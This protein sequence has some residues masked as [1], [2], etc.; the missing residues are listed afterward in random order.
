MGCFLELGLLFSDV[1]CT[2]CVCH[3]CHWAVVGNTISFGVGYTVSLLGWETL[4]LFWMGNTVSPLGHF[5][6]LVLEFEGYQI[7]G[8]PVSLIPELFPDPIFSSCPSET[9][10]KYQIVYYASIFS[11]GFLFSLQLVYLFHFHSEVLT[12]HLHYFTSQH[13]MGM[14]CPCHSHL[15]WVFV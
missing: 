4:Y 8:F 15:A 11:G 5:H 1:Y 3:Q 7:R 6:S 10:T 9:L 12:G 14:Q 13:R 2:L